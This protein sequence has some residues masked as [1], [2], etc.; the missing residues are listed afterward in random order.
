MHGKFALALLAVWT[1]ATCARGEIVNLVRNPGF[2]AAT[3]GVPDGYALS[4]AAKW[5]RAGG[6]DEFTSQGIVFPGDARDG[7]QCQPDGAHRSR[8]G[9]VAHL[10]LPRPGRGRLLRWTATRWR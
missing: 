9:P 6:L 7:G 5:D 3:N 2:E 8:E 1:L 10:P 4:G